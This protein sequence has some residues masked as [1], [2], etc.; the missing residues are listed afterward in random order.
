MKIQGVRIKNGP[1]RSALTA[2]GMRRSSGKSGISAIKPTPSGDIEITL[3]T[4]A[5]V[6]GSRRYRE[7]LES[8]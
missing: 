4:G 1:A 6:A 8:T 5:A 7:A 2:F 3:D